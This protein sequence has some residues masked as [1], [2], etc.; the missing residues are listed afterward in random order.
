MH[1]TAAVHRAQ[2]VGQAGREPPDGGLGQRAVQAHHVGQRR[3]GHVRGGQPGR[4]VVDP[5]ADHGGGVH[6]ADQPGR[7]DLLAEPAQ[8]LGIA[9]QL[10][11]HDLDRHRPAAGGEAEVDAAHA[12][13]AEAGAER[14][15]PDHPR[16]VRGKRFH[17]YSYAAEPPWPPWP[18][19]PLSR[20]TP[21]LSASTQRLPGLPARSN[22]CGQSGPDAAA[23]ELA[24]CGRYFERAP[25]TYCACPGRLSRAMLSVSTLTPGSPRNSMSRALVFSA[26]QLLDLRHRQVP[27]RGH[28]VNLDGR[29]GR[30]DVRVEPGPGGR[31]RVRR[32]L[33]DLARG[34]TPRSA[35]G[36]A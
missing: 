25:P 12:A 30:R 8:E 6:A 7:R 16:I 20:Q 36:A 21:E 2:R 27:G 26:D 9:G 3:A 24:E 5:R 14:E 17:L 34:R 33:R 11:V 23:G 19:R 29:V 4:V 13:R 32:D 18:L 22:P 1:Q 15:L 35:A 28:P 31:D 10:R